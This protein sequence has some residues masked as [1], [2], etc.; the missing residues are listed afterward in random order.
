ME[1]YHV[2]VT[3]CV[4]FAGLLVILGVVAYL[5]LKAENRDDLDPE[6]L[7]RL[8]KRTTRGKDE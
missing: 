2:V 8:K 3:G 6:I 4:M 7:E 1:N 5:W